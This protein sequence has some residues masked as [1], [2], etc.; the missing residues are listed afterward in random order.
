MSWPTIERTDVSPALA[1]FVGDAAFLT[2]WNNDLLDPA[3]ID[4]DYIFATAAADTEYQRVIDRT[5]NRG[6]PTGL[7]LLAIVGLG[8]LMIIITLSRRRRPADHLLS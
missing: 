5:R 4:G 7:A 6:D 8:A 2:R 1:D 3:S